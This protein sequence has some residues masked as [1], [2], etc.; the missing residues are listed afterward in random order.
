[1]A[2][3]EQEHAEL[4]N[5]VNLEYETLG[6]VLPGTTAALDAAATKIPFFGKALDQVGKSAKDLG[7]AFTAATGAMY[8]GEKGMS[9]YNKSVGH[10]GDAIESFSKGVALG[11]A[12]FNPAIAG[13]ILVLGKLTK[14]ATDYVKASAKQSDELFNAFQKLSRAGGAGADSLS[15]IYADMQKLGL[16]VQDLDKFVALVAG[17][18]KELSMLSGSV[19]KGRRDFAEVGKSM[20]QYKLSLLNSG[21][22]QDE[23]NEGSL[24]YLRLQSRIGMTQKKSADE[25]AFSTAKYLE[26]Q[27]KLTQ[28]TGLNRKEQ[29]DAIQ[30]LRNDE[31]FAAKVNAMRNSGDQKQIDAAAELEKTY[32]LLASKSQ[33]AADGFRDIAVGNLQTEAAQKSQRTTQGESMRVS[34][35]IIAGQLKAA[36]GAD[37][38]VDAEV[39]TLK[40][41]GESQGTLRNYNKTFNNITG[42]IALQAQQ[43]AGGFVASEKALEKQ[44]QD[45]GTRNGKA[46][47]AE[48]Q[49]QAELVITQQKSMHNLQDF[50]RL[51]VTPSTIAMSTLAKVVK[52][53]TDMLPGAG[54]VKEEEEAARQAVEVETAQI[55]LAKA[56]EKQNKATNEVQKKASE[57]EIKAAETKLATAKKERLLYIKNS[58]HLRL[59]DKEIQELNATIGAAG[60]TA[61]MVTTGGGAA[62]GNINIAKQGKKAGAKQGYTKLPAT[63]GGGNARPAEAP[64]AAPAAAPAEAPMAAPAAAPSGGGGGKESMGATPP[65]DLQ[66]KPGSGTPGMIDTAA[67]KNMIKAHEGLVQYPYKD[68]LGKWTIGIGHLIGDGTK[69]PPEFAAWANNGPAY[70]PGS[71]NNNT[72]PAWSMEKVNQVFE[73]DLQKSAQGAERNTKNFADM[74]TPGKTGFVDLAFNMGPNWI[75][76]KG[77]TKLD[78][79]LAAKK[80]EE[81][82]K[83]LI[84]SLWYTQVGDRG[85][86]VVDMAGAAFAEKGGEF[87]GPNSGYPATLHGKE[88]VIPLENNSGNFVKMFEDIASSNRE[89]VAMMDEMVRVHRATNGISEKMLRYAQD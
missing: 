63:P 26:E 83:E 86:K 40:V 16:G 49:R 68:I 80:N 18:S 75:K 81:I 24:T 37:R 8:A 11:L 66:Q 28:L 87:S 65:P 79:A 30:S 23:I 5:R 47:N 76:Q 52:N 25:L 10:A 73:Q 77:F 33:S 17:S 67:L 44:R 78:A 62:V 2:T 54:K 7:Q 89:M 21:M 1:M 60:Q 14:G 19:I 3:T 82:K 4:L 64:M 50:I 43:T 39:R 15:G 32:A 56:Q 72:T 61:E 31:A 6:R 35:Q 55:E 29:E 42:A 74:T 70:G 27:D 53:L 57:E 13:T 22:T 84:N 59:T 12:A 38:M 58:D 51:G 20:E 34:Q 71:K 36:E 85:K 46:K 41:F 88:A 45:Q 69:L 48:Q 9:A